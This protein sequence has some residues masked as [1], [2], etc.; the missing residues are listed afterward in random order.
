MR[1]KHPNLQVRSSVTPGGTCKS[2][3]VMSWAKLQ[4]LG[5][6]CPPSHQGMPW[7]PH[8]PPLGRFVP[9]S[10]LQ[11]PDPPHE[12]VHYQHSSN[13]ALPPLHGAGMH[14]VWYFWGE[15]LGKSLHREQGHQARL[16]SLDAGDS[17][18]RFCRLIHLHWLTCPRCLHY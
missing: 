12:L 5:R 13:Q 4:A 6:R 7:P 2:I 14:R 9:S 10:N 3:C 16:A 11:T 17:T 8:V 18:K 1:S 15:V